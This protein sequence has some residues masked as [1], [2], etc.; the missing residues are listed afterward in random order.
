[1]GVELFHDQE[2][3]AYATFDRDG[4]RETWPLRSG[5]FR[6]YLSWLYY[7][8]YGAAPRAATLM[9][10]LLTLE[11]RAR[12]EGDLATA[13]VRVAPTDDGIALDLGD[14]G[15]TA[16]EVNRHGWRHVKRPTTRFIRP[17]GMLALPVPESGGSIAQLRPWLSVAHEDDFR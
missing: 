6:A 9:E 17:R 11:G 8:R 5:G 3:R 4:H 1:M 2:E 15:W 7:Q 14:P 16:V 13:Y 10:L 12:F